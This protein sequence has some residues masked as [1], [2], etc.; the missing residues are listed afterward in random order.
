MYISVN[1]SEREKERDIRSFI[2]DKAVRTC[3]KFNVNLFENV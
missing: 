2:N 1:K 3:R